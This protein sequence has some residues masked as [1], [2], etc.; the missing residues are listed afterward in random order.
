M[1]KPSST[2]GLRRPLPGE[3][4]G[5]VAWELPMFLHRFLGTDS[6]TNWEQNTVEQGGI[7]GNNVNLSD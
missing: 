3:F 7:R 4:L 1:G 6:G 2:T 5:G